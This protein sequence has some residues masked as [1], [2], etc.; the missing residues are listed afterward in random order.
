MNRRDLLVAAPALA[1]STALAQ[2][3]PS[4]PSPGAAEQVQARLLAQR[5]AWNRGDL[6]AFCADY[7]DDAVFVSPSGLTR[8]R[9]EVFARY[10]RKYGQA[11]ATMG[12]LEF[13]FVDVEAGVDV[14]SVVMRWSL[15]FADKPAA[16]GM[17]LVVWRR[18]TAGWRLAQD[19]SF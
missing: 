10:D 15:R 16:S 12:T 17:T 6:V 18:G 11:K 19:A 8:G 13:D 7:A 9:A 3:A 1:T 14:V 4:A 5:D 2:G